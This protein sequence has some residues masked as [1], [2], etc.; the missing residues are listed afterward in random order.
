M[1]QS[2]D[3]VAKAFKGLAIAA[4]RARGLAKEHGK[5][6]LVGSLPRRQQDVIR[7]YLLEVERDVA[8]LLQIMTK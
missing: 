8:D 6:K 3:D 7:Q 5:A 1:K 2:E 4:A